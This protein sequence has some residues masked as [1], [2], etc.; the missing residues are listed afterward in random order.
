MKLLVDTPT[1]WKFL[2]DISTFTKITGNF[3][4]SRTSFS[5]PIEFQCLVALMKYRT[6]GM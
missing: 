5:F 1:D 6:A 3:E 4:C 2:L